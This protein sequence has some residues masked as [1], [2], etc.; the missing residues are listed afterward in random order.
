MSCNLFFTRLTWV[1]RT[2]LT[3]GPAAILAVV[4]VACAG[5]GTGLDINGNPISNLALSREEFA[6]P[7][8]SSVRLTAT[9]TDAGGTPV[10]GLTIGW[11]SSNQQ[12]AI[13][14]EDGVVTAV[15]SGD[16]TI[17]AS[18][19][20]PSNT[21]ERATAT[22][23]VVASAQLAADVQP[24]F[25]A[26]CALSGCHGGATP[27]LGQNLTTGNAHGSIVNVAS[28][29]VPSLFR[30]TPFEPEQ[31]YLVHKIRGTQASVG[32]SGGQM[33]L[34]GGAL[35]DAEINIIRAWIQA[36]AANN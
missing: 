16:V 18:V 20:T 36:G 10:S 8:A 25:S 32:G 30:V 15:G 21:E 26:S 23:V 4:A 6:L 31:S 22:G 24:I 2:H 34:G 9:L 14:D 28:M 5:D 35:P 12:V 1:C 11:E 3:F 27:Q 19:V 7:V 13:V 17:T 29:E 33:P